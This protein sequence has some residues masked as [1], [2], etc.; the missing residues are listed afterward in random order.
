MDILFYKQYYI[1]ILLFSFLDYLN[2]FC[3]IVKHCKNLILMRNGCG[4]TKYEGFGYID[5][6]VLHGRT[7][8]KGKTHK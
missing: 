8:S 3:I 6:D 7:N 4:I 5:I 2:N 1:R